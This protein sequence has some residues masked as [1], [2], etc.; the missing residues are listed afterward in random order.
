[1]QQAEQSPTARK[2]NLHR[3]VDANDAEKVFLS[4]LE[5][6]HLR[7]AVESRGEQERKKHVE[8]DDGKGCTLRMRSWCRCNA[9]S[10][11]SGE[12]MLSSF[13]RLSAEFCHPLIH[14]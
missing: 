14:K 7:A 1:M 4:V 13:S 3:E 11:R 2:V 5:K 10:R 8:I 12:Q 9:S 6:R